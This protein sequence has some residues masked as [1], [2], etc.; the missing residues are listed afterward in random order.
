MSQEEPQDLYSRILRSIQNKISPKNDK[1]KRPFSIFQTDRDGNRDGERDGERDPDED[2]TPCECPPVIAK[3]D[4]SPP[5]SDFERWETILY[6]AQTNNDTEIPRLLDEF[7]HQMQNIRDI[8]TNLRQTGSNIFASYQANVASYNEYQDLMCQ[9][10]NLFNTLKSLCEQTKAISQR[11]KAIQDQANSI[12]QQI[13]QNFTELSP[14][15]PNN[16]KQILTSGRLSNYIGTNLPLLFTQLDGLD[17]SFEDLQQ[18]RKEID[19]QYNSLMRQAKT[20]RTELLKMD[21]PKLEDIQDQVSQMN[22]IKDAINGYV[23][24][25]NN[26][27][28]QLTNDINNVINGING[29]YLL[30]PADGA[31]Q[32]IEEVVADKISYPCKDGTFISCPGLENI[33]TGKTFPSRP[34]LMNNIT[35]PPGYNPIPPFTFTIENQL[36]PECAPPIG[37][38]CAGVFIQQ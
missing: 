18:E 38:P 19:R 20:I 13:N 36:S 32:A 31:T 2:T 22:D 9:L 7:D 5:D 8:T 3:S 30:L 6:A 37:H 21:P 23:D 33:P 34:N 28:T 15:N 17:Q 16:Y 14:V 4:P 10:R 24:Q 12:F 11:L 27:S 1:K 26:L 29:L 25:A 35:D